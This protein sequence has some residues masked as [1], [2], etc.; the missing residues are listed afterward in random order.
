MV[1]PSVYMPLASSCAFTK[2]HGTHHSRVPAPRGSVSS[3][4]TLSG[5]EL[6]ASD[7]AA[8]RSSQSLS[9]AQQDTMSLR[10]K[11]ETFAD[12]AKKWAGVAWRRAAAACRRRYFI[13]VFAAGDGDRGGVCDRTDKLRIKD[14]ERRATRTTRSARWGFPLP[15][16]RR[17]AWRRRRR[18]LHLP[19][20][21]SSAA[22][23]VAGGELCGWGGGWGPRPRHAAGLKW[24]LARPRRG[25]LRLGTRA[26]D[27]SV[28]LGGSISSPGSKALP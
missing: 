3:R 13:A 25:R 5:S 10:G 11:L 8:P 23:F 17:W 20:V 1:P 14:L 9:A 28:D 27:E 2:N 6:S 16:S 15:S 22:S 18:L 19:F 12:T 24:R 4:S 26:R 7:A 21:S